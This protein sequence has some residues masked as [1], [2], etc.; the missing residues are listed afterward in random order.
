MNHQEVGEQFVIAW[1]EID[2][3]VAAA[4]R[5]LKAFPEPFLM[6][7]GVELCCKI[8]EF[9]TFFFSWCT[10]GGSKHLLASFNENLRKKYEPYV[11]EIRQISD[12]MMR[13]YQYCVGDKVASIERYF[14]EVQAFHQRHNWTRDEEQW[15]MLN[16][17]QEQHRQ[18]LAEQ[19]ENFLAN[20]SQQ[21]IGMMATQRCGPGIKQI[22]DREAE[23]FV[24]SRNQPQEV[25]T[26][27][28]MHAD[29]HKLLVSHMAPSADDALRTKTAVD[30]ASR[31]LDPFFEYSHMHPEVFSGDCFIEADVVQQLQSWNSEA[32]S[33][34]LAIIG[35]AS[36]TQDCAP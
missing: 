20:L 12:Y 22:L 18:Q 13:G 21:L 29:G 34:I 23:L 33:S 7:L 14:Q 27:D 28:R 16:Q 26:I 11:E 35:P 6:E 1:K 30:E 5:E 2:R 25:D 3:T 8:L 36:I 32:K 10:Q 19:T 4:K 31:V 17:S 15:A 9:V 24:A